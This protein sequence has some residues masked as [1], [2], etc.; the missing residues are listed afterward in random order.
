M[1]INQKQN[2][3]LAATNKI[4]DNG[5]NICKVCGTVNGYQGAN[6][7]TNFHENMYKIVKKSV[8]GRKYHLENVINKNGIT[9]SYHDVDKKLSDFP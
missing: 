7:Y 2:I 3:S 5:S 8:Y 4:D 6:E 9:L 1:L